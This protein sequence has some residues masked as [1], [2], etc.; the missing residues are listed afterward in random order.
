MISKP[1]NRSKNDERPEKKNTCDVREKQAEHLYIYYYPVTVFIW[2]SRSNKKKK[3][4]I[5][6]GCYKTVGESV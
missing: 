2:R 4:A 6:C 3:N 1:E 5:I